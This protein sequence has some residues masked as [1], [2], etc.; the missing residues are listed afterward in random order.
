VS[1]VQVE[2]QSGSAEFFGVSITE[3]P[4]GRVT[5]RALYTGSGSAADA[6]QSSYF[7]YDNED[8]LLCETTTSVSSCP[9]SAGGSNVKNDNSTSGYTH[10]GD[11][12]LLMRP[13]PGS[14][15]VTNQ[16]SLVA[17]KHQIDTLNQDA[18][19][20]GVTTYNYDGRGFRITDTNTNQPGTERDYEYDGA[21][22]VQWVS[23]KYYAPDWDI[24]DLGSVYDGQGRRV[25]KSF[26]DEET[27]ITSEWF[28]YYDP[29]NRLSEV[30]YISNTSDSYSVRS[31]FQLHWLGQRPVAYWE[32]DVESGVVTTSIRYIGTDETNRPLDMMS[33]PSGSGST[34]R[35]W[36]IN[37]SAWGYDTNVVGPSV[38]QPL[39]FAAQYNDPETAEWLSDGSSM[40]APGVVLDGNRTYDPW[41]GSYVQ[42]DP[43]VG[44]TRSSYVYANDN[45]LTAHMIPSGI[46][47]QQ[48]EFDFDT[49]CFAVIDLPCTQFRDFA[50][51]QVQQRKSCCV[52]SLPPRV[53]QR[54]LLATTRLGRLFLW[55]NHRLLMSRD[56]MG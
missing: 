50:N 48:G 13:V 7:I 42:V 11:W 54:R 46:Q 20:N 17:G 44:E 4:K 33:W 47:D 16:F 10:A 28:F 22:R 29:L 35:V 23:G 38:Y 8:R 25:F 24:Y 51:C 21:G 45:P 12:V 39:L 2:A 26:Y 3:D 40:Y 53:T 30:Y 55:R 6:A 19:V 1:N 34:S 43:Y 15:A 52:P 27:E 37:P 32:S 31:T 36:A 41:A 56:R 14:S 5:G 9:G 18:N 49:S